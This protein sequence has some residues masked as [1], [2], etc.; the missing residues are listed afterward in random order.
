MTEQK[1]HNTVLL[2]MKKH[3][4]IRYLLS[5][6]LPLYIPSLDAQHLSVSNKW[7]TG[8]SHVSQGKYVNTSVFAHYKWRS[9]E[10]ESALQM[11]VYNHHSSTPSAFKLYTQKDSMFHSFPLKLSAGYLL[12]PAE[13]TLRESNINLLATRVLRSF[14]AT[15]GFN[16]KTYTYTKE[17]TDNYA[18]NEPRY[19]EN[20]GL[21]YDFSY[22]Y[23]P[24]TQHWK[25]GIHFTNFDDFIVN[26]DMNPYF[27]LSSEY[28]IS[29]TLKILLEGNYIKS[30]IFN[31]SSN[32][33]GYYI[34]TGIKWDVK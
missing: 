9:V 26:Q 27:R 14:S 2:I 6:L 15:L 24:A 13:N 17:A 1:A 8:E 28:R 23:S 16:F 19:H 7:T 12:I 21:I 34:K 30:G 11:N 18:I 4:Y 10:F 22:Y 5:L 31:G 29:S 3:H 20:W 33:Y 32:Y 25:I